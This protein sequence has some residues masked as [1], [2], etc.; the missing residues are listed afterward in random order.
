MAKK[1]TDILVY[2]AMS[3]ELQHV[4][5]TF[6]V[7]FISKEFEKMA[8]TAYL[9]EIPSNNS[10]NTYNIVLVAAG[11]MGNTSSAVITS[12]LI[13]KYNP[14]NVVV[15]GIAGSI[16][17]DLS[18]GDIF[19]PNR[20]N[21]YLANGAATGKTEV[22]YN[23][24]GN[25][26]QSDKRLLNRFANFTQTHA[27]SS[28]AWERKSEETYKTQV[29][30]E[31]EAKLKHESILLNPKAKLVVGD[32][33]NLASGPI[34]GKG[35]AFANFLKKSSDRK[36]TAIEMESAGVYA[37]A[38][39]LISPPRM[40]AIRGISDL[41]TEKKA[42]LEEIAGTKLRTI[43]MQNAVHLLKIAIKEDVFAAEEKKSG[44]EDKALATP[45][46]KVFLIGGETG[47]GDSSDDSLD[48][49]RLICEIIG[50]K[51]AK[52]GLELI[53]CSPF[54]DAADYHASKAYA[55]A[56]VGGQIHFHYPA[57]P[58][59]IERI[60]I[61]QTELQ[62]HKNSPKISYWQHPTFSR[63]EAR[64]QAWTL[65][66]LQ[67]LEQADAVV[68]IGG[69]DTSSASILLHQAEIWKIPV[70]PY[71]QIGG[72]AEASFKRIN[73]KAIYPA[74][75]EHKIANP[76][77]PE[78]IVQLLT[79][80]STKQL[81]QKLLK[82][83][84]INAVFISRARADCESASHIETNL[85]TKNITVFIGDNAVTPEKEVIPAIDEYVMQSQLFISLWTKDYALSTW[86]HDE[87]MFAINREKSGL[88][89][90]IIIQLDD[91]PIIPT[92]ARGLNIISNK[93][94][95]AVNNILNDILQLK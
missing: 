26:F 69:K 61:F 11:T 59:V 82:L 54:N 30:A 45:I 35:E 65:C 21:E 63:K 47:A 19:I 87:L 58:E 79:E 95:S 9:A 78:R 13:T 31:I 67:A 4:L 51:L 27:I 15:I 83:E 76:R 40:L 39:P 80:L 6:E 90:V 23:L 73:W 36:N 85:K 66:Q 8:L 89:N 24:S 49:C 92:E 7:N 22:E 20:V 5:N 57:H 68:A 3:E 10:A 43:C 25:Y 56:N 70:I 1:K 48:E 91:T 37:S 16:S 32:D 52:G 71:P 86:C 64:K 88:M 34:V 72:A 2:I 94:L 55:K 38:T 33:R 60:K 50:K 12:Q 75:R 17:E 93:S 42:K 44:N 14:A 18:P 74:I 41:A 46:K 53:V 84:E 62:K 29:T 81:S 77:G 28:L